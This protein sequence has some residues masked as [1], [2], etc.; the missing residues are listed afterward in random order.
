MSLRIACITATLCLSACQ[1]GTGGANAPGTSAEGFTGISENEVITALGNEPFWNARI[2]GG[3]LLYATPENSAGA[4]IAVDRFI[5]Q[6][7]LGFS[8]TLQ[9]EKFDLLV[10]PG[11]C[12]DTMSDRTYPYTATLQIGGE[13]RNGCAYT[14][15]QPYQG[16]AAP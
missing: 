3:E 12:S 15:Q 14:D 1:Q 11:T 10:T 4:T 16:D 9:G 5:G 8:G 6:G 2:T 13:Q 7:G